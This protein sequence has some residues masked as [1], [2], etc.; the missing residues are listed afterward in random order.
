MTQ[1]QFFGSHFPSYL[2]QASPARLPAGAEEQ[3]G[4]AWVCSLGHDETAGPAALQAQGMADFV[5]ATL[6]RE[7]ESER[8]AAGAAAPALSPSH[9]VSER[10][11]EEAG[12][13]AAA[14]GGAGGAGGGQEAQQRPKVSAGGLSP[15]QGACRNGLSF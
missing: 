11:A 10:L 13:A 4:W 1:H 15:R 14:G 6:R 3:V 12:T 5:S 7:A 2:K 8:E 9:M